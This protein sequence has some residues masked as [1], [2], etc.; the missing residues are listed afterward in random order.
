MEAPR[1]KLADDLIPGEVRTADRMAEVQQQMTQTAHPAAARAD[2]V[3]GTA[4]P[5]GPQQVANLN[6]IQRIHATF[7]VGCPT[8]SERA[9]APAADAFRFASGAMRTP[10]RAI[11]SSICPAIRPAAS[12]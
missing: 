8:R 5:A 6:W 10:S 4:A 1:A 12:G 11:V 3:N 9:G 2:Q 7:V